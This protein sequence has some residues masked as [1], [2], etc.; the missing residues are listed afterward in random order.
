MSALEKVIE[1]IFRRLFRSEN[2][3]A[4]VISVDKEANTCLVK[5]AESNVERRAKLSVIEQTKEVQLIIYPE[6]G[7]IVICGSLYNNQAQAV[8]LQVHEVDEIIWRDGSQGG[9]LKTLSFLQELEKTNQVVNAL[10]ESFNQWAVVPADG[11]AALKTLATQKLPD[12]EV[13]DF[14]DVQDEKFKV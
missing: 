2:Y 7:S 8:V 6:V 1:H 11:G 3:K 9:I 4:E 14:S 12:K 13:G 10:L 5:D